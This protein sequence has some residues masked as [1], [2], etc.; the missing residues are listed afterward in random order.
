MVEKCDRCEMEGNDRRTLW[1]ACLYAMNEMG[2]PF[3]MVSIVNDV[4]GGNSNFFTLRV[5]KK[6]RTD[7]ME[8]IK[9][10]FDEKPLHDVDDEGGYF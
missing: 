2:L 10:W 9:K 1:M 5:C 3:E 7:W 8:Y 4:A 6:C